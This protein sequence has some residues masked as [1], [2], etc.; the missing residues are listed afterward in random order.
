MLPFIIEIRVQTT[1]NRPLLEIGIWCLG[2]RI[3]QKVFLIGFWH[4]SVLSNSDLNSSSR[5]AI[6]ES[7][8]NTDDF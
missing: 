8:I 4:T 1:W 2:Y 7:V 6:R 5:C 3:D